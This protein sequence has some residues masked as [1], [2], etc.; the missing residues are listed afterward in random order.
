MV[1]LVLVV[2]ATVAGIGWARALTSNRDKATSAAAIPARSAAATSAPTTITPTTTAPP[3]QTT[4][5]IVVPE[6]TS[7]TMSPSTTQSRRPSLLQR[8]MVRPTGVAAQMDVDIGGAGGE[9]CSSLYG[10]LNVRKPTIGVGGEDPSVT[11]ALIGSPVRICLLRF[12]VGTPIQV[13]IRS[14]TGRL[15]RLTAP[16]PPCDGADCTTE[17]AW[18]PLPG[19]QLGTYDVTA[20]QDDVSVK[21]KIV[22]EP[23]RE[24]SLMVIGSTTDEETRVTVRPGTPV[25]IAIAGFAPRRSV[26]LLFYY[27]P[28]FDSYPKGLR[29]RASTTVTT[30]ATGGA[31]FWLRTSPTDPLGCYLVNTWP[32]LRAG[33][34]PDPRSLWASQSSWH[35]F[36]L[37]R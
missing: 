9:S 14:P 35:Q 5:A 6:S 30:D 1:P 28:S 10:H 12:S 15:E 36:C 31:I 33:L 4:H 27:T 11:E 22:V 13:T 18:G 23:A 19:Y 26:G 25:G 7:T 3:S 21:A 29:F 20:A 32:P 2:L 34:S 17:T 8:T 37:Q 16:A 24:P